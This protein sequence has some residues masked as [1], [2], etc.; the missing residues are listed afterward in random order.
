MTCINGLPP[1]TPG[2]NWHAAYNATR[3]QRDKALQKAKDLE[4]QL[5]DIRDVLR[6]LRS[7]V[8][9]YTA[10]Y[11]LVDEAL[12]YTHGPKGIVSRIDETAVKRWHCAQC[13][14]PMQFADGICFA[15]NGGRDPGD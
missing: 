8:D 13:K 1:F 2:T 12:S 6:K 15:C 11:P 10:V 9:A 5:S 14:K 7:L 3:T 4:L